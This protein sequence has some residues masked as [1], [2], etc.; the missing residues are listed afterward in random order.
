MSLVFLAFLLVYWCGCCSRLMLLMLRLV[1]LLL[2]LLSFGIVVGAGVGVVV[3]V[4]C[5]R[6]CLVLLFG[7]VVCAIGDG[8]AV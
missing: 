2:R 8:A 7:V 3:A 4:G 5:F 6:W 1:L